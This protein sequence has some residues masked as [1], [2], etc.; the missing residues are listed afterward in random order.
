MNSWISLSL[1]RI[2]WVSS[3]LSGSAERPRVLERRTRAE[4]PRAGRL[5]ETDSGRRE[6]RLTGTEERGFLTAVDMGGP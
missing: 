2:G 1:A 3:Q 4:A 6:F 5:V